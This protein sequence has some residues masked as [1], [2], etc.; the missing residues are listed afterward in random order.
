M[1]FA[2]FLLICT[3]LAHLFDKV[4]PK[5]NAKILRNALIKCQKKYVYT[6][7][8]YFQLTALGKSIVKPPQNLLPW[9]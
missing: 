7:K 4:I 1:F 3:I 6:V 5:T 9:V 2:R 8:E